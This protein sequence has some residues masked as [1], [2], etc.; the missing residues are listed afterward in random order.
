MPTHLLRWDSQNPPLREDG[1]PYTYEEVDEESWRDIPTV[2]C[3]LGV[4]GDDQRRLLASLARIHTEGIVYFTP[5][6]VVV[7]DDHPTCG[8][9]LWVPSDRYVRPLRPADE[10]RR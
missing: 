7:D 2:E 4:L 1:T 8:M 5:R 3:D 9:A 6:G 10:S